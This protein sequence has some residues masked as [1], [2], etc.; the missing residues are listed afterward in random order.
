VTRPRSQADP[1]SRALARAGARVVFAP[2]IRV[3][4]PRSLRALDAAVSAL[5]S[6]DAVVFTSGT[7]VDR[8]FERLRALGAPPPAGAVYAVG[9]HTAERVS[10]AGLRP[11]VRDGARTGA[12]LGRAMPAVSGKKI[13]IPRAQ[14]G[15]PSLARILRERGATVRLAAA[16]RTLPDRAGLRGLS[17]RPD[18]VA[19]ASPSAV[20]ALFKLKGAAGARALLSTAVAAA[21]GPTTAAALRRRGAPDIVVAARPAPEEIVRALAQ[22]W[23]A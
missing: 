18:A 14:N 17:G 5:G 15:D 11:I 22:R 3:A 9:P 7:S 23:S 20:E 2:L 6:F 4:P 10:A 8:F 12:D 1:L 16:Y 19:F 13:L 21:I